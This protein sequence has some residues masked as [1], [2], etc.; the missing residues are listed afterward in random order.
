MK[1][2][3]CALIFAIG[4]ALA[5]GLDSV[6]VVPGSTNAL[7]VPFLS[8][9][10]NAPHKG[11]ITLCWIYPVEWMHRVE[12]WQVLRSIG[13]NPE[14]VY[15]LSI[16]KPMQLHVAGE[17]NTTLRWLNMAVTPG[18][19]YTYRVVAVADDTLED[20]PPSNELVGHVLPGPNTNSVVLRIP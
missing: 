15:T 8:Q 18:Q 16:H 11:G 20:S 10:D 6:P 5:E 9:V 4:P 1:A 14:V 17:T 13:T 12:A 3:L 19:T 7:P 2:T